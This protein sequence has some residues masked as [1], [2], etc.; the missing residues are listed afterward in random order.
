[1]KKHVEYRKVAQVAFVYGLALMAAVACG[2]SFPLKALDKTQTDPMPFSVEQGLQAK[3]TTLKEG[4]GCDQTVD[5]SF[6]DSGNSVVMTICSKAT[7]DGKASGISNSQQQS[8][9][10]P[11][12]G[13]YYQAVSACPDST[14]SQM[15]VIVTRQ[16]NDNKRMKR[17]AF[18]LEGADNM[19][20]VAHKD[21]TSLTLPIDA[22]KLQRD[23]PVKP[24]P[25]ASP[26]PSPSPAAPVVAS[27]VAP[28][29]G[30]SPAPTPSD[31]SAEPAPAPAAPTPAIEVN[32]ADPSTHAM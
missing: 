31:I 3:K 18:L 23:V 11:G 28:A 9:L 15:G 10:S 22:L 5:L 14:C 29:P 26:S 25:S 16:N 30:A 20:V 32:P 6:T 4:S 27:P 7:A 12:K 24:A 8:D 21:N 13:F 19:V 2:E 1:M 17:I